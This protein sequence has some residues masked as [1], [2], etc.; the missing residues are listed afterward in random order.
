MA[1]TWGEAK[2]ARRRSGLLKGEKGG[3]GTGSQVNGIGW[4][5]LEGRDGGKD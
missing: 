1:A 4:D 3:G 2:R 5:L